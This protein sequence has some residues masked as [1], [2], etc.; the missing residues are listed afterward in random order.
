MG[1]TLVNQWRSAIDGVVDGQARISLLY[2]GGLDSSVIAHTLRSKRPTLVTVGAIGAADV[3]SATEG[4]Q[5]LDLPL[6]VRTLSEEDVGAALRKWGPHLEG[7][8]ETSRLVALG[9][10]LATEA[11]PDRRVLC[12]QGADELFLGYAHFAGIPTPDV[13]QRARL[14]WQRLIDRDWPRAQ[15]LASTL[16]RELASPYLDPAFVDYVRAIPIEERLGG[17]ERK[18]V[19]R[20]LARSIGVPTILVERPKKALQFG[21]G[22]SRLLRRAS[23]ARVAR[24]PAGPTHG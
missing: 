16:D 19:L 6:V 20:G 18:S 5:L 2:S 7:T 4:A 10:G 13:E 21:S 24:A 22:L 3:R 1:T 14:D 11:A 17:G 8:D 15:A 9:I 12:G 23:D